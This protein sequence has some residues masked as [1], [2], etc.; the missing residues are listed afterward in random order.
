MSKILCLCATLLMIVALTP[1]TATADPLVITSGTGF[2]TGFSGGPSF[3]VTG[4]NFA[5]NGGGDQGSSTPQTSCF[6]C[7][8]GTAITVGGFFGGS[9]VLHSAT[10]N[11]TF[12]PNVGLG[13]VLILTG[14]PIIVP[15]ST[16]DLILTSPFS[17]S[18]QL[19]LCSSNCGSFQ[20][21]FFTVDLIGS[22][23]ATVNLQ[24]FH[25]PNGNPIFQFQSVTYDFQTPEPMSILLLGGGLLGLAAKL[26]R[27]RSRR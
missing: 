13:G 9:S 21:P 12:Y 3:N 7:A 24:L 6:P 4:L 26:R 25:L 10:L 14:P 2:V 18:G 15:N 1:A 16:S 27:P 23:I 20:P 11:G 8:P 5:A 22:G 19:Q 17:F